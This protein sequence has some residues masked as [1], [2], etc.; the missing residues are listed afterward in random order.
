[1]AACFWAVASAG[2]QHLCWRPPRFQP[3]ASE[4]A[5][6]AREHAAASTN[7]HL[8][9]ARALLQRAMQQS[10]AEAAATHAAAAAAE[11][12]AARLRALLQASADLD[13]KCDGGGA[14]CGFRAS[15]RAELQAALR[16]VEQSSRRSVPGRLRLGRSG[17]CRTRLSCQ[18]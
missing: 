16:N 15:A 4:R 5:A 6:S 9:D 12:R 13:V 11:A 14:T 17:S 3:R 2:R 1:M 8:Q 18:S 7:A 10:G